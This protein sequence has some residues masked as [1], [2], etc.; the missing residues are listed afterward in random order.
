MV[1]YGGCDF[2]GSSINITF[3]QFDHV[4]GDILIAGGSLI[5]NFEADSATAR[6]TKK[7]YNLVSGGRDRIGF[8]LPLDYT[9]FD[10]SSAGLGP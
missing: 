3:E 8:K 10:K 4:W 9:W 1:F 6:G 2:Y 7:S 5:N